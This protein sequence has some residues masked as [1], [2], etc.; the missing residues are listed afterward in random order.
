M[1]RQLHFGTASGVDSAAKAVAND[2]QR[3]RAADAR[4][5]QLISLRV[6]EYVCVCVCR[7][8]YRAISARHKR[9]N[10]L[11]VASFDVVVVDI[12]A[13]AVVVVVAA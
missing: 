9:I 12:I 7:L 5:L 8:V 11:F 10:Q 6:C 4:A 3:S 13:S 2:R 1:L